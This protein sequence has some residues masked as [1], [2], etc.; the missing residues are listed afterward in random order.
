MSEQTAPAVQV[1]RVASDRPVLVVVEEPA[2]EP[3]PEPK[4]P[5]AGTWR[6]R[7]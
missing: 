2:H 4:R 5:V 1:V 7:W 3:E 6:H